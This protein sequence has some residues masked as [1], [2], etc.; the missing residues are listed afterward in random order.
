M[1]LL[2][3]VLR[4]VFWG[5]LALSCSFTRPCEHDALVC[6]KHHNLSWLSQLLACPG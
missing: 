5:K 4:V 1:F 2:I 3:W 6:A